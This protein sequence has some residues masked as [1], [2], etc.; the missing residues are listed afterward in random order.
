MVS[1]P[2][3]S[4]TLAGWI[5]GDP[6]VGFLVGGILEGAHLGGLPVGGA[7]IAEPG[8]AAIPGVVAAV[9]LG[10]APGLAVGCGLG[11]VWSLVGGATIV[12]Q[13]RLNGLVI[14][15]PDAGAAN[16]RSLVLRHWGCVGMDAVRGTMLVGAGIEIARLV[17]RLGGGGWPLAEGSTIGVLLLPGAFAAGT[18]ARRWSAGSGALRRGALLFAGGVVAG[19]TLVAVIG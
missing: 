17:A 7:R 2:L 18:L 4:G 15:E 1:R 19:W 14:G 8:P 10:G 3:V 16:A 11:A 5:L 6:G 12:W 9:H 13:R